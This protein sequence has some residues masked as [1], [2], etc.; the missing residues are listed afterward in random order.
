MAIDAQH[1]RSRA[2]R[3]RLLRYQIFGQVVIEVRDEHRGYSTIDSL[4]H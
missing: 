1:A 2:V 4:I 3:E